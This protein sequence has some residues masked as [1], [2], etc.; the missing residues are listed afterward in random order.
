MSSCRALMVVPQPAVEP[1]LCS[2]VVV[3]PHPLTLQ[4]QRHWQAVP[5]LPG[6]TLSSVLQRHGIDAAEPGWLVTI[7]GA[8]VPQAMWSRVRPRHGHLIEA[9]RVAGKSALRIAALIAVMVYAPQLAVSMGFTAGTASAAAATIAIQMAGAAIVNRVLGPKVPRISN[10][11]QQTASTYSLSGARNRM[12]HYEPLGLV[13][14]VVKVV[15]DLMA[16]P[17]SWFD[18]DDQYLFVRL[19]AGINCGFV[20]TIK[21]GATAIE[22]YADVTVSRAA[23][24]GIPGDMQDWSSVDTVA[25]GT[26]DAVTSPGAYVTRTSSAGTVRLA[27]DIGAQ[28]YDMSDQGTFNTATVTIEA[29]RRLL[30]SGPWLPFTG[31]S[32]AITLTSSSTK[33]VRRTIQSAT[34]AS[35][36]YEVRLRKVTANISDSRRANLVE[37]ATLKSVQADTTNYASHPQVGIRIRATGQLNGGLDEVNWVATAAPTPVWTGSAWVT[38]LTRNPGAQILQLARGIY[39]SNGRLMAG[40]GWADSQIDIP[41][42]QAFMVHCATNNVVFDHWFDQPASCMEVMEAMAAAG[43][44]T[45]DF[46]PGQLTVVWL[47]QTRPIE[48]VV[49]MANIKQGS[50]RVDYTTRE[51]AQE[52][53][54][55]WR[56]RDDSWLNKSMRAVAPG[57]TV[58]LGTA[59][60]QPI[61]VTTATGVA[62]ALRLAMAQNIYQRKTV[63]WEMDLEHI[64]FRRFML[65]ALSHDMT[66]WGYGGQLRG[67]VSLGGGQV[68]ITLDEPVPWNSAAGLRAVGLRL[69][70]EAQYRIFNVATFSGETRQ[71][72]LTTAWPGGVPIPGSTADNPA[73]DTLWIYDFKAVPG[74]RLCVVQ[75]EPTADLAGARITAV[76]EPDEFWTY[77]TTGAYTVPAV[78]SSLAV[79]ASNIVVTQE[80]ATLTFD[81]STQLA[82]TF[83]VTGIFARAELWMGLTGQILQ[84]VGETT[85]RRF[86]DVQVVVTGTYNIEVRPFDG[87]GRR[88]TVAARTYTVALVRVID[89]TTFSA[90]MGWV[91]SGALEGWTAAG[92]T[93]TTAANSVTLQSTTADPNFISPVIAQPGAAAPLVRLRVRRLAGTGW[94][95]QVYYATSGHGFSESFT[96]TQ[97]IDPTVL[98]EWRV[99]EWDM[100]ALSAGGSD[101]I[102]STITQVRIDLGASA[103]DRFEIDWAALGAV[104]PGTFGANWGSNVFGVPDNV[105]NATTDLTLVADGAVQISGN[106]AT[107]IGTTS[108]WDASFRSQQSYRGGFYIECVPTANNVEWMIGANTSTDLTDPG[109]STI[110]YALN[111]TS[112]GVLRF[113]QGGGINVVTSTYASG[114]VLAMKYDGYR[115]EYLKNGVVVGPPVLPSSALATAQ[116]FLDSSLFTPG[117]RLRSIRFMPLSQLSGL[118]LEQISSGQYPQFLNSYQVIGQNLVPESDQPVSPRIA[119][120]SNPNGAVINNGVTVNTVEY[121]TVAGMT[122]ADY[123]LQAGPLRNVFVRQAGR[124]TGTVDT[125]ADDLG[126]T[127]A[128][129]LVTPRSPAQAG[130]RYMGSVFGVSHR[131]RFSVTLAFINAN[132]QY[133]FF[134]P[135]SSFAGNTGVLANRL[136]LYARPFSSLVAPPGT[137]S[138]QLIIRKFNTTVGSSDSYLWLAAPQIEAAGANQEGPG[139]YMSGPVGAIGTDQLLPWTSQEVVDFYDEAGMVYLNP[140]MV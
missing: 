44:G 88:G 70:G 94:H 12:R 108:A 110:D 114:D 82:V 111:G 37:W 18:S 135:A 125:A 1:L 62:R 90:V 24:P 66:Q 137:N 115:L 3:T 79:V 39:D 16:Q 75:I 42:L 83:D 71:L 38:Q 31:A 130:V 64:T 65:L 61:G 69:P 132:G 126:N 81:G 49:S 52:I 48:S 72:T 19:H 112:G 76:P 123:V 95:G 122:T 124:H 121:P 51:L 43:L 26:L 28:L 104:L 59:R 5:L 2:D 63:S 9:R 133:I 84:R 50:F 40:L 20:D 34:L 23:F 120:A 54:A 30:P 6:E 73:E 99:V 85:S 119:I 46:H 109:F 77:M 36:Q 10:Y 14:G 27:I 113:V 139:P 91:F 106:T 129:D 13:F 103:A 47:S 102:N 128:V 134:A 78:G 4:H 93:L 97:P 53:E 138:C 11:D 22:S 89:R 55:A 68:R 117:A 100:N 8:V 7:G 57:V 41:G 58:P 25:G 118:S 15:P 67:A 140:S 116:F 80:R 35:G 29:E 60:I 87:L 96:Q 33:P 45:I 127:V 136:D 131:C 105:T 98:N 56:D 32:A 74:Q 107:K 17:Y 86:D 92:A 101:W 21:I